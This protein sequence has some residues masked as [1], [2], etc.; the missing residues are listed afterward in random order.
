ML[1]WIFLSTSA[2]SLLY[3]VW[4]FIELYEEFW[5]QRYVVWKWR[6]IIKYPFQIVLYMHIE[7]YTRSWHMIVFYRVSCVVELANISVHFFHSLLFWN[8]LIILYWEWVFYPCIILLPYAS[9]SF[10][11]TRIPFRNSQIIRFWCISLYS[12]KT[13]TLIL[14]PISS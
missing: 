8:P 10:G 11:N 4:S 7:F 1:S 13:I 5:P 6:A 14:P 3:V 9:W 12:I 2:F